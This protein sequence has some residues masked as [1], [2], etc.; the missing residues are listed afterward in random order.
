MFRDRKDCAATL[1]PSSLCVVGKRATRKEAEAKGATSGERV[2]SF[3]AINREMRGRSKEKSA[4]KTKRRAGPPRSGLSQM[5]EKKTKK[6][7][8]KEKFEFSIVG[9]K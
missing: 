3:S 4:E 7:K 5:V 8:G 9:V 2:A 6:K 1:I